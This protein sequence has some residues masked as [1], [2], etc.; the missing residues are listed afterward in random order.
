MNRACFPREKH[1][2]SQKW[3]KFM[4]FSFF[5]FLWFGL[6]G[7]LLRSCLGVQIST[8][9]P[10]PV[11]VWQKYMRQLGIEEEDGLWIHSATR[12]TCAWKTSDWGKVAHF[13][14]AA[15]RRRLLGRAALKRVHL[16]G[17]E[18]TDVETTVRCIRSREGGHQAELRMLM[19]DGVW[20][21]RRRAAAGWVPDA[22]CPFC[23]TKEEETLQH[24]L[25]KCPAWARLRRWS[26]C[27]ARGASH[28]LCRMQ[29]VYV[30]CAQRMPVKRCRLN[31]ELTSRDAP[32]FLLR[33]S[34]VTGM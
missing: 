12:E 13:L 19:A 22:I 14:R 27:I 8:R 10:S 5:P 26:D 9:I 24:L 28:S 20:T 34:V 33:G 15:L 3:A 4:N 21:Q 18:D 23:D 31:G 30:A 1:Q 32:A 17:A 25:H 2:N 16:R 7:R 11:G 29:G 6:P